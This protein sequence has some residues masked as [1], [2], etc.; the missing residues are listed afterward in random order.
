MMTKYTA[1]WNHMRPYTNIWGSPVVK[2]ENN[3]PLDQNMYSPG[4]RRIQ[5]VTDM[6]KMT[7]E[8]TGAEKTA[9]ELCM[10]L[11]EAELM[12]EIMRRNLARWNI[13]ISDLDVNLPAR[14][15]IITL[16]MLKEKGCRE[17]TKL[18]KFKL[19]TSQGVRD[20]EFKWETHL[21]SRLSV[22]YW[23]GVHASMK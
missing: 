9:A 1:K 5:Y 14:P 16:I 23:D 18:L 22:K 19:G 8:G 21:G 15:A 3:V 20:R 6:I 2:N 10:E 4:V 7:P 13:Q 11:V 17:W 12:L